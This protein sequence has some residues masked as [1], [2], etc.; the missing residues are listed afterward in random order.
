ME[1]TKKQ[2]KEIGKVT[3]L[4]FEEEA[5]NFYLFHMKGNGFMFIMKEWPQDFFDTYSKEKMSGISKEDSDSISKIL[6]GNNE[7]N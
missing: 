4:P 5:E 3:E 1:L 6:K 2:I 7:N